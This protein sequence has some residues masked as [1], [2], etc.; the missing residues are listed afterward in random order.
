MSI[1]SAADRAGGW[2]RQRILFAVL[3]VSVVLNVLFIAGAVWSRVQETPGRG[4]EQRLV[5][6]G[7]QLDLDP[8]QRIA[9][10]KFLGEVR[11]RGDKAHR[12]V[13]PLYRAAWDAAGRPAADAAAVLRLFDDAF[14]K[15]QELNRETIGQTL[16]FMATLSPEQRARFVALARQR[17]TWRN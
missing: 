2:P 7:A 16:D 6:I 13:A 3:A 17:R 5:R 10:E 1:A 11:M 14:D 4:Y 8:Q 12:Q 15:R 9:F